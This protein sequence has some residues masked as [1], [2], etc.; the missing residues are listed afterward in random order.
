MLIVTADEMLHKGLQLGGYDLFR[1]EKVQRSKNL[2]RFRALYGSNPVVYAQILEDLQ[3]TQIEEARV[4]AEMV[5]VD[6]FLM[7][8]HFLMRYPTE[9]QLSGLFKICE[10][11][12]RKPSTIEVSHAGRGRKLND[13]LGSILMKGKTSC[14]SPK[15]FMSQELSTRL[16]LL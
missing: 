15:I 9:D 7:A 14:S 11:T 13:F 2:A 12:A 6:S 10:R 16:I 1:Q 5:C 4:D 8:M 3:A